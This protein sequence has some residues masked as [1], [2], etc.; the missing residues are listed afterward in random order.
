MP[1]CGCCKNILSTL[2]CPHDALTGLRFCGKH[3][4]SKNPKLWADVNNTEPK[5]ILIQKIWRGYFIRN[6]LRLSGPGVLKRE[7]C[8]NT[9]ELFTFDEKEKLYPLDYFAFEE[10]GKI[11]WFDIRTMIQC[12]DNSTELKNPYTRQDMSSESRKRLHKLYIYRVRRKLS[13]SHTELPFRTLDQI[14]THRFTHI[15]HVLQA[16]DFFDVNPNTFMSLGP[17]KVRFYVMLLIEQF[18]EW[19]DEQKIANT[20]RR[21][22]VNYLC[23]V[24]EK[25]HN[26]D[27]GQYLYVLS[28]VL[29]FILYDSKDPF[30]PCFIIMSGI[31]RM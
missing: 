14:L 1:Q 9:E 28:S 3:S 13:I 10:N 20:Q 7:V 17:L 23:N 5:A 27:Y 21:K 4:R 19:S 12:M 6:I 11:Y 31:H 25:F 24:A 15:S 2:R 16:Y 18:Q 30:Q 26:I 8:S 22:F 29:L